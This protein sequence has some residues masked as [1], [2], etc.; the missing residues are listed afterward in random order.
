[1]NSS[2]LSQKFFS[3]VALRMGEKAVSRR[4]QMQIDH[5]ATLYGKGF[6]R[7]H[8]ENLDS[9]VNFVDAVLRITRMRDQ[10]RRNSLDFRI[11]KNEILIPGLPEALDGFK[12]M[13]LTDI[14]IDGFVDGG[15]TLFS[16]VSP[17]SC[18]ICV[19]TGD[20]RLLTHHSHKPAAI[21]MSRLVTNINATH[22]IYGILGNHDFLEQVP[23]LE[24]SGVRMLLNEGVTIRHSGAEFFL[25]G[26]DDPHFYGT[27]D[28]ER[29]LSNRPG[30][31]PTVLLSHSPEMY[32]EAESSAVD[33]YLCGHTHGGQ[34]C[35]PGGIP[36]IT[37]AVCPRRMTTGKWNHGG[38][39]GYTSRGTGCS[40]VQARF[41][42][43]PEIAVHILRRRKDGGE[44]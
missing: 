41:N 20:Y 13:H 28:L 30:P 11:E 12:I 4:L 16:H 18:N 44:S 3:S 10:G 1:M 31:M 29:A 8:L 14:H 42:C 9:F 34:I 7:V 5:S 22:G 15:E 33:L 21:G 37:H 2:P 36:L 43:P 32:S 27:H 24:E 17:I 26:V 35:L 38:M 39:T 23:A 40:G 6:G 19:L 25:A